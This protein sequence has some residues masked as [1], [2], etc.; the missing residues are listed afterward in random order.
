[1]A[2][3]TGSVPQ[4]WKERGSW[5]VGN[6]GIWC[7]KQNRIQKKPPVPAGYPPLLLLQP[8]WAEA[9]QASNPF[10]LFKATGWRGTRGSK[11]MALNNQHLVLY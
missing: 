1:M 6:G 9:Q 8:G 2:L 5:L 11:L 3:K 10:Q 4:R 7:T